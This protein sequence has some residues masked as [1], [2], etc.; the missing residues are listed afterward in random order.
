MPSPISD[1]MQNTTPLKQCLEASVSFRQ[2]SPPSKKYSNVF[3]TG[4]WEIM[5]MN[6]LGSIF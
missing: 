4:H 6:I 3:K 1:S 5:V 2:Q